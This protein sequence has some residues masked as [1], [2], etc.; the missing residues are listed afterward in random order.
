MPEFQFVKYI[1]QCPGYEVG[2]RFPR[3]VRRI[4]CTNQLLYI[5]AVIRLA[6]SKRCLS[7]YTGI[8]APVGWLQPEFSISRPRKGLGIDSRWL[9]ISTVST[10]LRPEVAHRSTALREGQ[11]ILLPLTIGKRHCGDT[12]FFG[13]NTTVANIF[14]SWFHWNAFSSFTRSIPVVAPRNVAA[15]SF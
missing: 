12:Q 8:N 6:V 11:A 9:L 5:S 4:P 1:F 10:A 2:K 7:T 13:L 15:C 14:R 3:L